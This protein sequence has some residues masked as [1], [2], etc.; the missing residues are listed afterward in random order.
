ML[1]AG[2]LVE[3]ILGAKA[4]G[5]SVEGAFVARFGVEGASLLGVGVIAHR[6]AGSRVLGA[7]V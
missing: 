3:K 1:R 5:A 6:V 2:D 7:G 4:I